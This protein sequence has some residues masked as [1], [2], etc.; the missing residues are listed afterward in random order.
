MLGVHNLI[1]WTLPNLSKQIKLGKIKCGWS[2]TP[3][4]QRDYPDQKY[5]QKE[6]HI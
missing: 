6:L 2:Y 4:S 1:N 3:F 5:Q